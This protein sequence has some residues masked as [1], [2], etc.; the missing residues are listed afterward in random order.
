LGK[1]LGDDFES[2]SEMRSIREERVKEGT[3]IGQLLDNVA[4]RYPPIARSIFDTKARRFLPHVVVNYN[5]RVISPHVV[6]DQLLKDG[7]KITI[8]PVYM[9]G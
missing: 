2:P 7:D 1:E 3:T 6:H 8:L 5:D 9:G 4:A